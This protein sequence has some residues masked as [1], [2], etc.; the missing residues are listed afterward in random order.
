MKVTSYSPVHR[1]TCERVVSQA[2]RR[3]T[4][5]LFVV[6]AQE[7]LGGPGSALRVALLPIALKFA[8]TPP[9]L[10]GAVSTSISILNVII[11]HFI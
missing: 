6:A 11:N 2:H 10:Q 9:V 5:L 1:S 7:G 8:R 4:Y 3:D